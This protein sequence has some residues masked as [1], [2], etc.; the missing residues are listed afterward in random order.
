MLELRTGQSLGREQMSQHLSAHEARRIFQREM[1]VAK[2][3]RQA[4][5]ARAPEQNPLQNQ[6]EDEERERLLRDLARLAA[7]DPFGR[8]G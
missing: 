6:E 7:G 4:R 1:E 5:E 8:T 2:Q 3:A